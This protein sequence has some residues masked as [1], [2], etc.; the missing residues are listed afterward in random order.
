[1]SLGIPRRTDAKD[2]DA[3]DRRPTRWVG[4][5]VATAARRTLAD[6]N[7]LLA[8]ALFYVI[9]TATVGALW[10]AVASASPG[11]ELVG[12]DARAFT[13]YIAVSE[14][15]MMAL[16]FRLVEV[17]GDDVGSGAVAA[18]M[19]RPAPVV[20]VRL[21]TTVGAALPRVV[22]VGVVGAVASAVV[23]GAPPEAAGLALAVPSVLLAL[24]VN[25]AAQHAV[26][27]AAFWL[28]DAKSMWFV[29]QKLVLIFGGVLLPLQVMPEW[30]E[31]IALA[32]P[33][34]SM[35]YAPARL[36]SGHVEP[37][38]L[39]TQAGWAVVMVVAATAAFAAGE[40]RLQAVGG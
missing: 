39:V 18:D 33:F 21:A 4:V 35:A 40:R 2:A 23:V 32:L 26:A 30:L 8:T 5:A 1:V 25:A 36:A 19:L 31:R 6:P 10:R 17:I 27:A 14:V 11:G 15:A 3:P 7:G 12:Y 34:S 37:V 20:G 24:V 38:L 22:T 9:A 13:W 29:Y 28:R 16:P